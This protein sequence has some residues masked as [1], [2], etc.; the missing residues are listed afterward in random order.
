MDDSIHM[1]ELKCSYDITPEINETM[2]KYILEKGENDP[3]LRPVRA[4]I[5]DRYTDWLLLMLEKS[6]KVLEREI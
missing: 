6:S 1:P 4:R 5:L 2:L 3:N